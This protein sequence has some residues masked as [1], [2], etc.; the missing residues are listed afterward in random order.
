VTRRGVV[1]FGLMS[2]LWGIPYLFIRIAVAEISPATLVFVR[3]AVGAA[4]LLPAALLTTNIRSVLGHWRWV[5]TFAVVEITIPWVCLSTAEQD[6][7]SSLAGLLIA[8]V[9]LVGSV[10]AVATGS[11]HRIGGRG[12]A[13][14]LVG[15]AGVAAIAGGDFATTGLVPLVL[16]AVTVIGYAVGPVIL[17]RQLVGVSSVAIMALSLA[18]N[19]VLYGCISAAQGW[20]QA[21][22][23]GAVVGSVVMLGI[24]STALAFL[25]F[26]ELI[27]EIGPVRATI[28]TYVNPAVAAILGVLV[29]SETFTVAMVIGFVLVTAGSILATR[30]DGASDPGRATVQMEPS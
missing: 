14:L 24:F 9:P 21:L 8:G 6:I 1:L 3:T 23:S 30:R 10:I 13:G 4:I 25:L 11:V 26:A 27:K 12:L 18:F 22:P 19:A 15:L 28:I 16:V 7:S 20:P 5:L 17:S 2:L 29:L